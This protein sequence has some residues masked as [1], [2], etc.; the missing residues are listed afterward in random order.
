MLDCEADYKHQSDAATKPALSVE[1]ATDLIKDGLTSAA[2]R[3][4]NTGDG[5]IVYVITNDSINEQMLP[6]RKD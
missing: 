4:V 6:L 1:R 2:E 3:D 5:A